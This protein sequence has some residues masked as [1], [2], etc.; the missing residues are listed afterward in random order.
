M[1]AV[2]NGHLVSGRY[3]LLGPLGH[4]AMGIVWR[5]KDELLDREVAIKEVRAA[6]LGTPA[7]TEATYQR[8]LREAKAAARLN[9]PG[10]VTV[11]DVVEEATVLQGQALRQELY[12]GYR[13]N[14]IR[15]GT[16]LHAPA[17]TW[18]F[19]W[20]PGGVSRIGVLELLVSI[21]TRAGTQPYVLSVS[22]P[23]IGFP[24]AAAVFRRVLRT[25]QPLP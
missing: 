7:E 14:A 12:P 11:F 25:F 8:T 21:T 13:L 6:G 2:S 18:R 10:V 19:S 24:G 4:G 1:R 20:R 5:G 23:A 22:A 3:R 16:F 17:A 9:H 15:P